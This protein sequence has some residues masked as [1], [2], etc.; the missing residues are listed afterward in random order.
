MKSIKQIVFPAFIVFLAFSFSCTAPTKEKE[1]V[2]ITSTYPDKIKNLTIYEVNVRQMT[3]EGTFKAFET[4]LPRLKKMGV[5]ILW[6]MPI[7]PIGIENRK[8]S[9]GS[10]YSVRDYRA[11][12]PEFG[13]IED[14]KNLLEKSHEMGFEVIIDWVGNHTS[15]DHAWMAEKPDFYT[16]D[17]TGNV[18]P[19]VADWSDVAD[20][21]Y[22][23]KELWDYMISDMK[24]WTNE[25]GIDGFRCDAA[26]W[27]PGEFWVKAIQE[28]EAEK[29]LLMLA[30]GEGPEWHEAGFDMTYAWEYHHIMNGIVRGEKNVVD[31]AEYMEKELSS[32]PN[33]GYRLI[34]TSNHDE[35]SWAGTVKERFGDAVKTFAALSF[36]YYGYPL[37]YSGQEAG[38]DKRLRFFDKDTISWEDLSMQSFYHELIQLRKDDPAIWNGDE[39]GNP[40]II[41]I[42]NLE[43]V[44]AFSRISGTNSVIGFFNLSD[45]E[46][47]FSVK[48]SVIGDY[49]DLISDN[50]YYINGQAPITLPPWGFMILSN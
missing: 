21:N 30:E 29:D 45:T 24:Y 39:G 16:R 8:G 11:V 5:G 14:F 4:H 38:M 23:N 15:W 9:L 28:L 33:G 48:E 35:N 20:L 44:L 7:H 6:F 10:Y 3:P 27:L 46:Q 36:T 34:F 49:V 13:T 41:N 18:I 17:S 25:I 2:E 50:Q 31:L 42:D 43:N 37:I 26:P 47:S 1:P 22:D 32:Y 12:N 40:E 19:P